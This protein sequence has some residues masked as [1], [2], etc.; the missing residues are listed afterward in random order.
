MWVH[1]WESGNPHSYPFPSSDLLILE[2]RTGQREG[3][4]GGTGVVWPALHR[5]SCTMWIPRP[6]Y[7]PVFPATSAS[8]HWHRGVLSFFCPLRRESWDTLHLQPSQVGAS[9]APEPLCLACPLTPHLS[10]LLSNSSGFKCFCLCV[11]LGASHS[12]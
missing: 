5:N 9:S 3:S 12:S 4:E 1:C 11:T 2:M 8:S 6:V 10:L 7:Q